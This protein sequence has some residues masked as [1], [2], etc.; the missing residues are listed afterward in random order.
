MIYR[1]S[2]LL[3]GV[4]SALTTT[5]Y[6]IQPVA[7]TFLPTRTSDYG[8]I[9]NGTDSFDYIPVSNLAASISSQ[10]NPTVTLSCIS[11]RENGLFNMHWH[12]TRI[13]TGPFCFSSP[14]KITSVMQRCSSGAQCMP[15]RGWSLQI[16]LPE[17]S[18]NQ[19]DFLNTY[20]YFVYLMNLFFISC[21]L[22]SVWFFKQ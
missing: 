22:F 2:Y 6:N 4:K 14:I 5:Q 13:L 20:I 21:V 1:F 12:V 16:F 3:S 8:F 17:H 18:F 10:P 11:S 9:V 7:G 19:N 15:W